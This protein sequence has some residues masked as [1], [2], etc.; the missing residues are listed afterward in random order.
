MHAVLY[1]VE[2]AWWNGLGGYGGKSNW[3]RDKNAKPF[4]VIY[5]A[6]PAEMKV[7]IYQM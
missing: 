7:P 2:L 5:K 1:S 4:P 6:M 3:V